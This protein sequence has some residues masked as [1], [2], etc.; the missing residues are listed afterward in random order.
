MSSFEKYGAL[1]EEPP[2]R[3]ASNEYPQHI[4][5]AEIR[6]I[7]PELSLLLMNTHSICFYAELRKIIP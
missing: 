5:Y 6:K 2:H 3:G 1:K 7:T 4:F